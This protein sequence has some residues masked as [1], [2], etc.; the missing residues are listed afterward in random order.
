MNGQAR[1][2]AV[3]V[4]LTVVTLAASGS[5]QLA[6][7]GATL[8][9]APRPPV[10]SQPTPSAAQATPGP[11]TRTPDRTPTPK[12]PAK[13]RGGSTTEPSSTPPTTDGPAPGRPRNLPG[14]PNGLPP[15][16]PDPL[17][18]PGPSTSP[19]P[20]TPYGPLPEL[21]ATCPP[22]DAQIHWDGPATAPRTV[23]LTFDDG[24]SVYTRQL[25]PVLRAEGIHATFFV[26]GK[27]VVRDPKAVAATA[28]AGHLV[29]NHSWDHVYPSALRDGWTPRYLAD[30]LR[31]TDAAIVAATG[32][33]T[34]Y[35]RTPGGFRPPS[36]L[37]VAPQF[38]EQVSLWTVDTRDWKI[39]GLKDIKPSPAA[40]ADMADKIY[41]NAITGIGSP[42]P[43][44]LMHD[45]G[46]YRGATLQALPRIIAAYRAAG[47]TFVRLDGLT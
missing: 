29:G 46:G 38:R 42:H 14:T 4:G 17:A 30:Q 18:S 7:I 8:D 23:A 45:A 33:P 37:A 6:A 5:G 2:L 25:L 15:A 31:R 36:V 26:V 24:P 28:A 1:L 11:A 41:A 43:V 19:D 20:S 27:Q 10:L 34:C 12:P 39:Q 3:V 16:S 13:P 47:Y 32:H 35:F 21:A 9:P 40:A 22:A 44:V